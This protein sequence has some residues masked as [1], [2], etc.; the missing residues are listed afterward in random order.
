MSRPVIVSIFLVAFLALLAACERAPAPPQEPVEEAV[1]DV[2]AQLD[3]LYHEYDE[4]V[5]RL[6]PLF[7]TFR[8]DH[9]FDDQ[10]FPLD[11]L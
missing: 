3:A 2:A 5:L 8:G 11:P 6:N 4:E 7:A 10:W 1:A 9:R